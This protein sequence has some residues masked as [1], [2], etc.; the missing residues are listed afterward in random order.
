M[1]PFIHW[2][3]LGYFY[4]LSVVYSAAQNMHV[5]NNALPWVA[6]KDGDWR[7]FTWLY[8]SASSTSPLQFPSYPRWKPVS[9]LDGNR[10]CSRGLWTQHSA[11]VCVCLVHAQEVPYWPCRWPGNAGEMIPTCGQLYETLNLVHDDK[12]FFQSLEDVSSLWW[13]ARFPALQSF[14]S[15]LDYF[16]PP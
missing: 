10:Q 3:T 5:E 8:S 6:S 7:N 4:L 14:S 16:Y 15:T 2:W 11:L 1:C 13:Q 9:S 12:W